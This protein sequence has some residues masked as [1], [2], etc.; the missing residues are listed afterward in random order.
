MRQYF[1]FVFRLLAYTSVAVFCQSKIDSQ[2]LASCAFRV[3]ITGEVYNIPCNIA[4]FSST[5]NF[6]IQGDLYYTYHDFC[7]SSQAPKLSHRTP[8]QQKRI[9]AVNRGICSF[10]VKVRNAISAGYDAVIIINNGPDVFPPATDS[11]FVTR[12]QPCLL[13]SV[14][15]LSKITESCKSDETQQCRKLQVRLIYGL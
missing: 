2:Y 9:L 13:V 8:E 1:S 7:T 12:G 3:I 15:L 14:E 4:L 10:E 6:D 11:G 5:L